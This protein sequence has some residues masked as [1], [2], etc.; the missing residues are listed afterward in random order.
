MTTLNK[1][2]LITKMCA[3][4]SKKLDLEID[5]ETHSRV[6]LINEEEAM[7]A[8]LRALAEALSDPNDQPISI[9][10]KPLSETVISERR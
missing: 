10:G 5:P 1:Q 6:T 9:R 8:A 2:A 7:E 4:F 3:A